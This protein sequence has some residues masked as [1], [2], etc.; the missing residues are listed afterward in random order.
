MRFSAM[1]ASEYILIDMYLISCNP[2]TK[3]IEQMTLQEEIL[4]NKK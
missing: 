1:L 3:R 4:I 2:S